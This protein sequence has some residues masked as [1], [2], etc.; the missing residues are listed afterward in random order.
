M[1]PAFYTVRQVD[2][3]TSTNLDVRA[4]AEKGA[5]EGLVLQAKRQKAGRGRQGRVWES[6]E[7][8][9]YLSILLRPDC[10]V[11]EA[12]VY[13]FV[14]ALAVFDTVKAVAP[15]LEVEIKWPN[16][17]LVGGRKICGILLESNLTSDRKVDW[18]VVG[19]GINVSKHPDAALV[20]ATSLTAEGFPVDVEAVLRLFLVH[21]DAWR[22]TYATQGFAP[23][24]TAWRARSRTGRVTARLA[25]D[26]VEGDFV[27]L[28]EDGHLLLRL[29]DG[30]EKAIAAGDVFFPEA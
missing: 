27:A 10:T 22:L 1:I 18:L 17:V 16:D 15:S 7:G 11:R 23:I 13:S 19:V 3:T 20:H 28:D 2:E 21:F 26:V 9:L 30:T 4:A 12:G 25:N 24:R 6:P 8:N 14:A 5:P 29:A